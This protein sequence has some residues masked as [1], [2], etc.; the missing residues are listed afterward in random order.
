MEKLE[1]LFIVKKKKNGKNGDK[2]WKIFKVFV[3]IVL[4]IFFG[5]LMILVIKLGVEI[6]VYLL[7]N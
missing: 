6:V 1:L 5:D 7:N 4:F 2:Y 3:I